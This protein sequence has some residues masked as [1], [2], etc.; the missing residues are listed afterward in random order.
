MKLLWD[1]TT[2][3]N[4]TSYNKRWLSQI[5][6]KDTTIPASLSKKDKCH[7]KIICLNLLAGKTFISNS[8]IFKHGEKSNYSYER[9]HHISCW[10]NTAVWWWQFKRWGTTCCFLIML[11]ANN[12]H[13]ANAPLPIYFSGCEGYHIEFKPFY[14]KLIKHLLTMSFNFLSAVARS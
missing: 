13:P 5:F 11:T 4:S 3:S 8:S 1:V 14:S 10:G 7:R 2:S 9:W 12:F 6:K